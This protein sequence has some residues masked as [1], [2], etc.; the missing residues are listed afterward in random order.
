MILFRRDLLRSYRSYHLLE[1]CRWHCSEIRIHE[2]DALVLILLQVEERD[3][4]ESPRLVARLLVD[5]PGDPRIGP[6]V[7]H[8]HRLSRGR[9]D[10]GSA[11]AYLEPDL[12]DLELGRDL[13]PDLVR[14]GVVDVERRPVRVHDGEDLAR[15]DLQEL[16]E[17]GRR[18]HEAPEVEDL[19]N[20]LDE[21]EDVIAQ[22][23]GREE[24]VALIRRA[25][26][27]IVRDGN[28]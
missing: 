27:R 26:G 25:M 6:G 22:A 19:L 24:A 4:E 21:L 18:A 3:A 2:G 23:G 7:G 16:L 1:I 12:L 8:V 14:R 10:A 13:G 11:L 5:R 17:V 28:A 20:D 9:R 15:H